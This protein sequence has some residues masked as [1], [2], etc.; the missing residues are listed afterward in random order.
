MVRQW[1]LVGAAPAVS[2][3]L[4]TTV[5]TKLREQT[6]ATNPAAWLFASDRKSSGQR[7]FHVFRRLRVDGRGTARKLEDVAAHNLM[8]ALS[9]DGTR[10]RS[11]TRA[12][13][14]NPS[15]T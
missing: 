6:P 10:W 8:P 7:I 15:S 12:R 9:A 14:A 5:T 2:T 13:P 1:M 3:L 4:V 11:S